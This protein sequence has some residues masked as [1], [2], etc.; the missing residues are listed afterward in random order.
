M[1]DITGN[2]LKSLLKPEWLNSISVSQPT[3]NKIAK[4]LND[5][6]FYP[7]LENIFNALNTMQPKNIKVVIIGQDPYQ[8]K[9]LAHGYSFSVPVGIEIPPSLRNIYKELQR[10][11]GIEEK[12]HTGNLEKWIPEGVLLLNSILTVEAGKSNSHKNI[13][14][15]IVT[16]EIIKYI[17]NTCSVV[18]LAWG[19]EAVK[20][21]SI[22]KNN[23]VLQ[24]GHP[25]PLNTAKP[26]YGCDCFSEANKELIK[27]NILPVRWTVLWD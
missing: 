10:E 26:F 13:G 18:F 24:Y 8:T 14:W 4:V 20:T 17:D 3:W 11:Y 6:N 21:C 23:V 27:K 25:S 15:E 12:L 16:N 2:T 9:G 7:K 5:C 1:S 19:N 22:V